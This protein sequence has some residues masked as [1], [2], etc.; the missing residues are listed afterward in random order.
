MIDVKQIRL[1]STFALSW[2]AAF[3]AA[4]IGYASMSSS[5]MPRPATTFGPSASTSPSPIFSTCRTR[6]LRGSPMNW[7]PEL[8]SAEAR[9]A[10]RAP[11]PNSMDLYFQ[12]VG[13]R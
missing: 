9:R 7:A 2:R 8:I 13:M 6:S 11:R 10:E 5:S 3:S 1:S 12:G 4:A